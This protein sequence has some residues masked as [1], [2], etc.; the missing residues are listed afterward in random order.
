MINREP[1][2]GGSGCFSRRRDDVSRQ[3]EDTM[4]AMMTNRT[5]TTG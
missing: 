5:G 2:I 4:A 3:T 1:G